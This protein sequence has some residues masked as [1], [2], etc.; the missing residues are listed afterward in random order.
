M[1]ILGRP[2]DFNFE[3]QGDNGQE[4]VRRNLSK[5]QLI[6]FALRNSECLLAQ[7][8][9]IVVNTGKFTGRSPKDKYIVNDGSPASEEIDWGKINQPISPESV[10][11]LLQDML[12]Y[13]KGK[14]LFL[15]DL[16]AGNHPKYSLQLQIITE[17]A[18]H[19]L[20]CKNLFLPASDQSEKSIAQFTIL[21]LPG[22]FAD[23]RIPGLNSGTFVILDFERKLILIGGTAYAGEIKKAVFSVLNRLLPGLGVL[24]M[25]CSA[26]IGKDGK[27]ALFFGLSGTGKTT[28]SSDPERFLIG[29]DETGWADDGIYN[30]EGGCYAKTIGLNKS[31]EP[32]IYAASTSFGAVLENVV[33]NSSNR[34]LDFCDASLSE[35]ARAAYPLE[36]IPG[37]IPTGNGGH[38]E[39]IFFLSADAFGVLPP[40]SLL[41][42]NQVL[43][44]FL[45]GFTAKLAGTELGL[46]K[47]PQATFS[48]C[49]AAPF[50]PLSPTV[51]ATLL[52]KKLQMHKTKV[53]L[54]NTGWIGGPYGVGE[55]IKLAYTRN[56]I[57]AALDGKIKADEL[58]EESYF[59][60]AIP[61]RCDGVPSAILNPVGTWKSQEE[62]A[63]Q[64][65]KLK[66]QFEQFKNC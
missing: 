59:H 52:Q 46:T 28:L 19:A 5:E 37:S 66:A 57:Q 62:Y 26:N 48:T 13:A 41:S 35:N 61:Q 60:L 50:L 51:Y 20:F 63:L 21:D 27:T 36:Y 9:A 30:F 29:D 33:L 32:L 16:R 11:S 25:H 40:I 65:Q 10:E 6:E 17:L 54:V 12:N 31:S 1:P 8:G 49:F 55:R 42:E 56:L 15:E 23:I 47:V 58:I 3:A 39:N 7:N 53:W 44:Y 45:A 24:P 34:S 64:A 43:S 4:S 22:F 14:A 2:S 18:W 38:P